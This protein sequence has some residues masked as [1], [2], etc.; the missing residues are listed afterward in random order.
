MINFKTSDRLPKVMLIDDNPGE[1]IILKAALK[2]ISIKNIEFKAFQNPIEAIDN[3]KSLLETPEGKK[4]LP[5]L[6]FL[7]LNMPEMNGSEALVILKNIEALRVIPIIIITTSAIEEELEKCYKLHANSVLQ[8]PM[9]FEDYVQSLEV[10]TSFWF[11][12]ATRIEVK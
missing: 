1:V 10:V 9:D 7:D 12:H 11:H 4:E 2:K 8:K 5:D 3:L 6:I